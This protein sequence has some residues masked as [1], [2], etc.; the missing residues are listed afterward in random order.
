L[1]NGLARIGGSLA[2][3]KRQASYLIIRVFFFYLAR[4]LVP[5][6]VCEVVYASGFA[7]SMGSDAP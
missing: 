6:F 3:A 2:K 7:S 5:K 1:A 4:M